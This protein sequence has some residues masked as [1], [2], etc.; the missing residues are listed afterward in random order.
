MKRI[1]LVALTGTIASAGLASLATVARAETC[2]LEKQC[3]FE[4]F[5]KICVMVKVCR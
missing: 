5:K 4:N 1:M 2:R 3:R